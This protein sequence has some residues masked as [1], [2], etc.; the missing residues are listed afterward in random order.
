VD[1]GRALSF[2]FDDEEWPLKFIIGTLLSIVP[3]FAQGYQVQVARNVVRGSKRPLPAH[4]QLG[5]VFAD[6][7][8][9]VA[10]GVVYFLPLLVLGCIIV[11]PAILAGDSD[12]GFLL[13]CSA[14]CCL[15]FLALAY[16]IPAMML[17]FMGIIRYAETGNY[18]EYFR[19]GALVHDVRQN[20]GLLATLWLYT[21]LLAVLAAIIAPFVSVLIVGAPLLGFYYH[22]ATGHLIGQA[23]QM[24]LV[25]Y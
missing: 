20:A 23:G 8:V 10:A 5:Q 24:I 1:F 15:F 7:V 14:T 13:T 9:V 16:A 6:G 25:G 22:I 2:P 17:V 3:F 12:L 4:N 19:L 21:F 11:V 18:G